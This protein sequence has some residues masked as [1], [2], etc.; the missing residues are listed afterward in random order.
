MPGHGVEWNE[1]ISGDWG[2]Q[3]MQD[4]LASID[5]LAKEPYVDE[6][7]L[8]AVGASYGGYSV[9]YLAGIHQ[10]RFKSFIAHAGVFNLESMYGTTEELF[11]VNWD[12]GGP[13]W[14]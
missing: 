9:F 4:Y 7:R 8:G 1:Q 3:V 6:T 14:E 11:F 12:M 2:G 10:N 13:Y 5:E